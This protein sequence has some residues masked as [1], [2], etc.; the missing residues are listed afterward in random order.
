MSPDKWQRDFDYRPQRQWRKPRIVRTPSEVRAR[1]V[2]WALAI[3][4]SA[5]VW[6]FLIFVLPVINKVVKEVS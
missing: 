5:S 4:F 2:I 3:V 6:W 1:L